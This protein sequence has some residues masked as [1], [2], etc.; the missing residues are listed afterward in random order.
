M[1]HIFSTVALDS[2]IIIFGGEEYNFASVSYIPYPA[3]P[4]VRYH[5]I[6]L[7]S[8]LLNLSLFFEHRIQ[9]VFTMSRGN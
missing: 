3:L 4:S 1:L 7:K 6:S 5:A 2:V 9:I 8:C